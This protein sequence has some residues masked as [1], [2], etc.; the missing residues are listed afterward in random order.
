MIICADDFGLREDIDQAILE[1]CSLG[2]LSAVSCM[3][4]L[5][6]CDSE[7]LGRLLAC[8]PGVDVGLHL[9]LTDERLPL[10]LSASGLKSK[11][12]SFTLMLQC[13]SLGRLRSQEV[14]QRV[15]AQY[16][17]FVQK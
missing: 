17:L 12:P 13:A 1:L 5:A 2:R 10:P 7:E 14:F 3:V 11:Q 15:S 16:E 8:P 9:C 6:R 4:A